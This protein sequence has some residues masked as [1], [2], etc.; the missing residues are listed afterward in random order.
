MNKKQIKGFEGIYEIYEDGRIYSYHTNKFMKN[1]KS[2]HGYLVIS[3][4]K[5]GVRKQ[6][7]LHRLLMSNF[8]PID[9]ENE[10]V[11][12][13]INGKKDDNRF[14][15]LEWCSVQENNDHAIKNGVNR[16]KNKLKEHQV[17]QIKKELKCLQP[18]TI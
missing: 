2:K 12:N 13:H 8:N 4:S 6:Y 14:E 7:K 5:N 9:N 16:G 11:I 18:N 17:I 10:Y 15:N 3:L 1:I